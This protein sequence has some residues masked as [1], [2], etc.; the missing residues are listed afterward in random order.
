LERQPGVDKVK[1]RLGGGGVLDVFADGK[2]VFSKKQAGHM[3][4]S[5]EILNAIQAG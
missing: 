2:L 1:L 5:Q 4:T 3:P